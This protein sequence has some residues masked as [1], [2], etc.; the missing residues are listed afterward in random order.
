M[1][2][3]GK[4]WK[5]GRESVKPERKDPEIPGYYFFILCF[6]P[7]VY[8]LYFLCISSPSVWSFPPVLFS[9]CNAGCTLMTTS[10]A[11]SI[12]IVYVTD[13]EYLA[14]VVI[15][16]SFA[17][18]YDFFDVSSW[19]KSSIWNFSIFLVCAWICLWNMSSN[20]NNFKSRKHRRLCN[21]QVISIYFIFY[22]KAD[23]WCWPSASSLN[24]AALLGAH[25]GL[26]LEGLLKQAPFQD[27]GHEPEYAIK[28][29]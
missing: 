5:T 29:H 19:V 11:I 25:S 21:R 2:K 24:L 12:T 1:K 8:Y 3:K 7:S 10:H 17:Y 15:I 20:T 27:D 6:H 4:W 23:I 16:E 13:S 14:L 18:M 28:G 26:R 9:G 22:F